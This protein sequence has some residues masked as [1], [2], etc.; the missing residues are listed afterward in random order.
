MRDLR[1]AVFGTVLTNI[2]LLIFIV[3]PTAQA[4]QSPILGRWLSASGGGV[5]E[6]YPCANKLCGK[7]VWIKE[8]IPNN[9]L[10]LDDR[11]PN[12]AL[13]ARPLCGLMMLGDFV[14][15]DASHWIDGWIYSPEN[16]KTYRAKITLESPTVLKL[17]GYIGISL[18]GETQ[19]WT[20]ADP[21]LGSCVAG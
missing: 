3:A 8:P 15:E 2:V 11:N 17:R 7:L 14:Q 16:G 9:P 21:A 4:Q 12:P 19:A 18:F 13:K 6:I 10:A 5:I 20:R 1:S